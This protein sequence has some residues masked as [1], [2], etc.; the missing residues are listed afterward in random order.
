VL[1]W[2]APRQ[3]G[4]S[5]RVDE[6]AKFCHLVLNGTLPLWC[7]DPPTLRFAL[8]PHTHDTHDTHDT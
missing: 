1:I 8:T 3:A 5:I 2:G 7:V 6:I 4:Y